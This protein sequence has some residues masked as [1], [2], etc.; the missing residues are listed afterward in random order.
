MAR[1]RSVFLY[2]M[3]AAL[4]NPALSSLVLRD[5]ED[6]L[7]RSPLPSLKTRTYRAFRRFNEWWTT[8]TPLEPS[9]S[10]LL[11]PPRFAS[12]RRGSDDISDGRKLK[13]GTP[14][15]GCS[16][17]S[18][19]IVKKKKE[20][21]SSGKS[22]L[23]LF[24]SRIYMYNLEN[25]FSNISPFLT[26]YPSLSQLSFFRSWGVFNN[27][28]RDRWVW[29]RLSR[30]QRHGTFVSGGPLTRRRDFWQETSHLHGEIASSFPLH[31]PS[32][33]GRREY[34][35]RWESAGVVINLAARRPEASFWTS[36]MW[37]W[38]SFGHSQEERS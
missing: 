16:R 1:S 6:S 35:K 29:Q 23:I 26:N 4:H 8:P 13:S 14:S 5:A 32:P 20:E 38:F 15:F 34:W 12:K 18:W 27:L 11:P 17:F 28:S 33:R 30:A 10:P 37:L 36:Q 21:R 25:I 19:N 2:C 7:C 24:R 22:I 31:P 3:A 9:S